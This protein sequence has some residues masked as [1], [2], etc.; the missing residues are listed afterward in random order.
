MKGGGSKTVSE[1]GEG[2]KKRTIL[3]EKVERVCAGVVVE[4]AR[5]GERR[6]STLEE[7]QQHIKS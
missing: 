1:E 4:R 5:G 6:G 2:R 7:G 3:K